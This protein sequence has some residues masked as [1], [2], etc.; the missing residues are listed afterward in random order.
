MKTI[1][2]K[3][4]NLESAGN[5]KVADPLFS[6]YYK[7]DK[8]FAKFADMIDNDKF[9]VPVKEIPVVDSYSIGSPETI[10]AF[11]EELA[12][13]KKSTVADRKKLSAMVGTGAARK[14]VDMVIASG[15]GA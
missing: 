6:N 2:Q 10:I 15:E 7:N 1:Y 9:V 11:L 8:V 3:F 12:E 4:L 13:K 5:K 14:V